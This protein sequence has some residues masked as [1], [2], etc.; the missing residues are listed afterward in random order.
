[1]SKM[2][3]MIILTP[4]QFAKLLKGSAKINETQQKVETDLSSYVKSL[5]KGS[6][7]PEQFDRFQNLFNRFLS[8]Q[9]KSREPLKIPI[10]DENDLDDEEHGVGGLSFRRGDEGLGS[11]LNRST[12]DTLSSIPSFRG[13]KIAKRKRPSTSSTPKAKAKRKSSEVTPDK[14]LLEGDRKLRWRTEKVN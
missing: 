5:G 8:D 3:K 2:S 11:V 14:N 4:E 6:P 1:M 12:H 10:H 7:K 9:R 13:F